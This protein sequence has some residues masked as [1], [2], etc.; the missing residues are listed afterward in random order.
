M[1]VIFTER[2][3]SRCHDAVGH[4]EGESHDRD[5]GIDLR[6]GREDRRVRDEDA[7]DAAEA[8]VWIDGMSFRITAGCGRAHRME[9]GEMQPAVVE[10]RHGLIETL[11]RSNHARAVDAG[12]HL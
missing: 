11:A 4:G 9:T 6:A 8:P 10:L 1:P 3:L 7:V 5:L 2:M 12:D